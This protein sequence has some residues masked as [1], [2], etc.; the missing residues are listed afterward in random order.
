MNGFPSGRD[1]L[2]RKLIDPGPVGQPQL[3]MY[4]PVGLGDLPTLKFVLGL[5]AFTRA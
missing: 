1:K 2:I 4:V 5:G 3:V